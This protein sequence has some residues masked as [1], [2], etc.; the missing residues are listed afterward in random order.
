MTHCLNT[1]S[2]EDFWYD[3]KN[4]H[5]TKNTYVKYTILHMNIRSMFQNFRAFKVS[6]DDEKADVIILSEVNCKEQDVNKFQID[7]FKI[8][9]LTREGRGG[10]LIIYVRSLFKC[11][12]IKTNFNFS[13]SLALKINN[14][15]T[16]VAIY[17]KPSLS[18]INFI[19]EIDEFL[20][21]I[22]D[23]NLIICG[24]MN[25][26]LL[27]PNDRIVTKYEDIMAEHGLLKLIDK[28]T[29]EEFSGNNYSS[30]L[31]DHMFARVQNLK[32][33]A[34]VL[35]YKISDHY[36]TCAMFYIDTPDPT[37]I[38]RTFV[39]Y[40]SVNKNLNTF[41]W[42]LLVNKRSPCHTLEKCATYIQSVKNAHTHTQTI[43]TKRRRVDKEWITPE[44]KA[45][46]AERC[47]LFRRSQSNKTNQIYREE[48]KQFRNALNLKLKNAERNFNLKSFKSC[49]GNVK[50]T[51]GR[52]NLILGRT[53]NSI[54][55]TVLRYMGQTSELPDILAG[56]GKY[57]AEAPALCSHTCNFVALRH[58][59]A[60]TPAQQSMYLAPPTQTQISKL[61]NGLK[62]KGPGCDNVSVQ[63]VQ[64]AGPAFVKIFCD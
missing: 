55:D 58:T 15:F 48:Y 50:K 44:L 34:A 41:D 45:L 59:L 37:K 43:H 57:F 13:E 53:V 16:V 4:F 29:R 32:Q 23:K 20:F 9:S 1:N 8:F 47:R 36:A 6:F 61:I 24:D 17:R 26:N 63:D 10:G 7:G 35:K 31:I 25:I 49:E 12:Q 21:S 22:E 14:E 54:D 46:A 28:P 62:K 56:F 40:N 42:N 5:I 3:V 11:K 33:I 38:T 52:L 39:D 27:D 60:H 19:K 51:W 18:K 30:T 2:I 64:N